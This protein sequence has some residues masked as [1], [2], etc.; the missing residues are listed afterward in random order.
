M[1]TLAE[2]SLDPGIRRW[3]ARIEQLA[4]SMP[5]LASADPVLRRAA[6]LE[7]SDAL[8]VDFTLPLP[9]GVDLD[10]VEL[11]GPGGALRLRRYRRSDASGLQPT[12]L[13][14]HGG[15]FYAG[16][17]DEVLND[18]LCARR[19]LESGVQVFSLDY[20]LSPEHVYPAP[21]L[22][23]V[24]AL[25]A[26]AA[27]PQRYGVDPERLGIGGNSAGAA[28]AAS[29]ALRVRD[30]ETPRLVHVDLEVPPLA[31]RR[32]GRSA[33]DYAIGFGLDALEAIVDMYTG[34]GGPADPLISPLDVDDLSGLPAT[35][36]LAAEHD[37]LRDSGVEYAER[38]RQAGVPVELHIG[39]GHLHGTPGITAAFD[40]AREWQGRHAQLLALAYDTI[41]ARQ[42][43]G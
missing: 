8:A 30:A 38:L 39:A 37:P 42:H 2:L 33:E 19:A 3:I 7:L 27:D 11:A 29:T 31:M 43:A 10:D 34:P 25:E 22:D 35:L 40:G 15:G 5:D 21:E 28:I 16:S 23:A 14:L 20:R 18:R 36:I 9:E 24:A 26:F 32:V 12:Q 13:W 41:P 1:T 6:D 4:P 17:I